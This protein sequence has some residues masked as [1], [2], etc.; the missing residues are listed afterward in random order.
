MILTLDEDTYNKELWVC[1]NSDSGAL[2]L[3]KKDIKVHEYTKLAIIGGYTKPL[4]CAGTFNSWIMLKEP[5]KGLLW[6]TK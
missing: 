3:G 6:T 2:G 1:G 5:N 4:I